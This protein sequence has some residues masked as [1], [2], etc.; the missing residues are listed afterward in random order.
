MT[1]V[2]LDEVKEVPLKEL[3]KIVINYNSYVN[4]EFTHVQDQVYDQV[5]II[6]CYEEKVRTKED[7]ITLHKKVSSVVNCK[8]HVNG[9]YQGLEK[10]SNA[11]ISDPKSLLY[12]LRLF[13]EDDH[14]KFDIWQ[15]N[16]CTMFKEKGINQETLIV[17]LNSKSNIEKFSIHINEIHDQKYS[18][19]PHMFRYEKTVVRT[20]CT[21]KEQSA[22]IEA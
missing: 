3:T 22:I 8:V 17:S 2:W 7:T 14:L 10:P 9:Y 18:E 21:A 16:D 11:W 15:N 1:D 13:K 6:R 19:F 5:K 4:L 20:N 12:M